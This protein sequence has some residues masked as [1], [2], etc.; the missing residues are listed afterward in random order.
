MIAATSACVGLA[1]V[2]DSWSISGSITSLCTEKVV[3]QSLAYDSVMAFISQQSVVHSD[4]DNAL[5]PYIWRQGKTRD[6]RQDI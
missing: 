5:L 3:D 4:H 6:M 2:S 1:V